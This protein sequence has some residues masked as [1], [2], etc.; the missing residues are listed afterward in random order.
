MKRCCI[1]VLTAICVS[2]PVLGG[3]GVNKPSGQNSDTVQRLVKL[4]GGDGPGITYLRFSRP[5]QQMVEETWLLNEPTRDFRLGTRTRQVSE[6]G[7]IDDEST[8]LPAGTTEGESFQYTGGVPKG[9]LLITPTT[10][11]AAPPS[12]GSQ[13]RGLVAAGSLVVTGTRTEGGREVLRLVG[14]KELLVG[15]NATMPAERVRITLANPSE[16]AIRFDVEASSGRPI[17]YASAAATVKFATGETQRLPADGLMFE[18][19]HQLVASSEVS[20]TVFDLRNVYP[21]ATRSP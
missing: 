5:R 17:R 3:C 19:V 18:D 11:G 2:V 21:K 8:L 20:K 15:G 7:Q 12:F 16:D 6:S 9:R 10:G 13:L 1:G 4:L 14:E